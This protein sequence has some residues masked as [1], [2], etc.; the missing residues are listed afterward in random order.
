MH[1]AK[2][3]RT[4]WPGKPSSV[5]R[6]GAGIVTFSEIVRIFLFQISKNVQAK[7]KI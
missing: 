6:R 4:V 7:T 3:A 2:V 5:R 1:H